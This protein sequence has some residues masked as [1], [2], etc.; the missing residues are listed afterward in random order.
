VSL[1]RRAAVALERR[2]ADPRLPWGDSTPPTNGAL[3]GAVEGTTVN[4]K[5]ALQVA[6][7][8]GSLGV[9]CDSMAMLR[10]E[11]FNSLDPAQRRRLPPSQLLTQPYVEISRMDWIVQY[12]MSVGLRG[13]FYGHVIERD[14]ELYPTQIKPIHPDNA[15]VQRV[16]YGRDK[17]KLEYRFDGQVV[18]TDDV[19][20]VRY[21]SVPGAIVGL[22]PIEY[23]RHTLGLA[24]A[25]D[26]YGAAYFQNSANPGGQIVVPDDLDPEETLGLAKAWLAAHQGI[27]QSN[28]PAVLTGGAEFK[29]ISITPEDSQFLESRQF[30]QSQ[31]SGMIF[32]VPPHMIGIVDRSTSWGTGIEQQERGYVT[33]TLSGYYGRLEEALT[34][35]HPPNR[36]V[37]ANL[38]ER[39]RGDTL[40]RYQAHSLGIAA[41]F[42]CQDDAR[43]AEGMAPLPDGLGETYLMPINAEPLKQAVQD[44]IGASQQSP[45]P[46][47]GNEE[48]QGGGKANG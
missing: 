42:L 35:V 1:I 11:L 22:N 24:R 10:L 29:P 46:G 7:V 26:L 41:G 2:G 5:A 28:I 36:F 44:S 27:G 14:P 25:Q 48:P 40:Q 31:I 18:P 12:T 20:H 32:R 47:G 38:S 34:A 39:L 13:N 8:Y 33:N 30:S 45:P 4:E 15:R 16:P 37:R 21:L 19:F 9:I 3:G 43:A 6:A 17:G 23:L